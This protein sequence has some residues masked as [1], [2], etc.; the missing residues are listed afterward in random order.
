[1]AK[2]MTLRE[3]VAKRIERLR[4]PKWANPMDHLKLDL[5]GESG[6]GPWLHLFCPF[7]QE[8][9]GRDP[10]DFLMF[11]FDWDEREWVAYKGPLPD[12]QAY[13]DDQAYYDGCLDG[14]R[15]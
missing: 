13:R 6:H 8:C 4:N 10:V 11:D 12:S 5:I 14:A 9:N 7:N 1:M 3:A 2:M 15:S